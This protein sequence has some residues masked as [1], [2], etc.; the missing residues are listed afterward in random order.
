MEL[1]KIDLEW[2]ANAL[3]D[4]SNLWYLDLRSGEVIPENFDA[5]F[6]EDDEEDEVKD[7][8]E[9][10]EI[11]LHITP[12]PSHEGY[13]IMEEYTDGLPEGRAK[14]SLARA[15][16]QPKPFRRFKDALFDFPEER[17]SWFKF[18]NARL[19]AAAIEFLR[20]NSIPWTKKEG[21]GDGTA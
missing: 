15:I 11:F 10:P 7:M 19:Q 18:Y 21:G 8:E 20:V 6:S 14:N 12:L 9:H 13:A 2:L 16:S 17:E 1:L 4:H 3:E 5:G